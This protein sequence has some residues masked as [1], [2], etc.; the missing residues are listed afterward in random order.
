MVEWRS[1]G[2]AAIKWLH[3]QRLHWQRLTCTSYKIIFIQFNLILRWLLDIC[4]EMNMF[5]S[6]ILCVMMSNF[7]ENWHALNISRM[8]DYDWYGW[9]AAHIN[10]RWWTLKVA[11][12][13]F[14]FSQLWPVPHFGQWTEIRVPINFARTN[15][16]MLMVRYDDRRVLFSVL[17][18]IWSLFV[19]A[20]LFNITID[21]YC[22][23]IKIHTLRK[24]S[25][26]S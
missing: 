8:V 22:T 18:G 20:H 1:N 12:Y 5:Y 15:D 6:Q 14:F 4:M 10:C 24:Y 26:H 9:N 19:F 25:K 3:R 21:W 17:F 7:H 16:K 11:L 2:F 23:N 13:Q